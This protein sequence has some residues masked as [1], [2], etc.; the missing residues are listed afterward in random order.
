MPPQVN[1]SVLEE[2]QMATDEIKDE[3]QAAAYLGLSPSGLRKKR[4]RGQGPR[5]ARL[6]RLIRYRLSWLDEWIERQSEP[7]MRSQ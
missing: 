3:R 1:F 6:G 2:E 5:Y 4:I 7:E